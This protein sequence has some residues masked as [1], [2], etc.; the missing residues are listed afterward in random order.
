MVISRFGADKIDVSERITLICALTA[1]A[2]GQ[3]RSAAMDALVEIYCHIGAK[4]YAYILKC[5]ISPVKMKALT[6]R[7]K[8]MDLI[9]RNKNRDE[10][11]EVLYL[12][13][14]ALKLTSNFV[15]H[16]RWL[17]NWTAVLAVALLLMKANTVLE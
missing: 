17:E 5:S 7:F 13:Y 15:C 6:Q 4:L 16:S 14:K 10:M 2:N 8:S 9:I 12:N 1:D 11:V 3:V